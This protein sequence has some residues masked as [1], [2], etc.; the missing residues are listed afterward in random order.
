MVIV[1][2]TSPLCYLILIDLID[3]LPQLYGQ[4]IIPVAVRDEL[5]APGSPGIVQ[6][7]ILQPPD[8]L[9]VRVINNQAD[10]ALS[11]LDRGEQEAIVLAEEL[12]ADLI[13]LDERAARR[14]ALERGL[15]IIGLLGILG[16][17]AQRDLIDFSTTL[18][19]LQQTTFRASPKLI[20]SLLRQYGSRNK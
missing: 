16:V 10:G 20:Q 8:W 19:R 2:D 18:S 3:L 11:Q 17:A 15:E 7:W 5:A 1:S 4:V 14:I 13:L 12:N 6:V 9:E